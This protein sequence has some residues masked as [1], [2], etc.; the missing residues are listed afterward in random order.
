MTTGN[1]TFEEN[2]HEKQLH[3]AFVSTGQVRHSAREA[4][5]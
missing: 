3:V 2:I 5:K 1:G 4:Q